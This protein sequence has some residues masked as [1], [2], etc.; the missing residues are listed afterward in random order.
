MSFHHPVRSPAFPGVTALR[1]VS[2]AALLGGGSR[3]Q[4]VLVLDVPAA[5]LFE[6]ASV[7]PVSPGGGP[8]LSIFPALVPLPPIPGP[9][10]P[11]GGVTI[12]GTSGQIWATNGAVVYSMPH[13]AYPSGIPPMPP[14]PAPPGLAGPLTGIAIDPVGGILW[15]TDGLVVLGAAPLP[16]LPILIPPFPILAPAAPLCGLDWDPLTGSLWAVDVG[17]IAYNFLPGGPLVGPPLPPPIPVPGPPTG[18]AIDKTGLAMPGFPRSLY[19]VGGGLIADYSTLV[20]FPSAAPGGEVGITV[21]PV[22][23]PTP[24]LPCACPT[25]A[26][27]HA[28][29]GPATTGS[30]T[31]GLA[32][33]GLPPGQLAIH[34]FDFAFNPAFPLVNGSGCPMGVNPALPSSFAVP[35]AAGP[36]GAIVTPLPL[37]GIPVSLLIHLQTFVLCP[38]DPAGFILSPMYRIAVSAP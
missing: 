10:A 24:P 37:F 38:A 7:T 31:F 13:V 12:D 9:L 5:T 2:L 35:T 25:F 11:P 36:G 4:D 15:M 34:V 6:S 19:V 14:L 27:A 23:I 17:G 8:V 22:P 20:L 28:V 29:L 33:T 30:A 18:I 3:A 21:H 26:P 1:V 16:G 32:L